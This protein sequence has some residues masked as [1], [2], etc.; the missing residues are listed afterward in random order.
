MHTRGRVILLLLFIGSLIGRP[1][2]AAE[3]RARKAARAVPA[4]VSVLTDLVFKQTYA[5]PLAL[6]LYQPERSD[7]P[8]PVVI[9]VH[10]GGWKNG[11]KDNCPAKWLAQHGFAVASISYR[12]I[13]DAQWPAQIE[14]CRDA[15][16]FLRRHAARLQLDAAR[17]GAW[18]SSAGG[19]LVALLGTLD[20]PP[21]EAVSSRVQAVCDWF[22]P[23]DL[24][25]M[26]PNVVSA[27]RPLEEVAKS[28]GARLLGATVRD[29]PELARQASALY[30]TSADDPPFLIVHGDQDPGVPLE[31]SERLAAALKRAGADA[32]LHVVK[33]AGHGG[34]LFQTTEVNALVQTFFE[35]TLKP[36]P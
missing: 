25:T 13:N 26:P 16:R 32:T 9:W 21:G 18:G 6:D 20:A 28:N 30:H 29:V 15:V 11:G 17:I 14:D 22:G 7:G 12:L 4:G 8:L 10:G 27:K 33:G 5:R 23:A 36:R 24:L 3:P 1:A 34:K 35:R 2:P 19:H 31:Q